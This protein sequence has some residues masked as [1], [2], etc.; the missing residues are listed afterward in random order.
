[1]DEGYIKFNCHWIE[2]PPTSAIQL[3]ELNKWRDILYQR[4]LIGAYPNGI[5][6]GNISIRVSG[7]TFIITGSATGGLS[8]LNESHF[9]LVKDYS[10]VQNSVT[11]TGPIK[12]SSESLSHAVIYE[13]SPATHAVLHIHNLNMWKKLID[14]VPTTKQDITYG[15]PEMANEIKRLFQQT[16]VSREKII[17]MAGH[18]EGIIA[19]G[20]TLDEAGDIL[21][22]KWQ[23]LTN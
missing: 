23:Q 18:T 9:V 22:A 5:G 19:F 11:C 13:C 3:I 2:A 8:T 14:V 21:L 16:D 4:G 10:F 15:T 6:F 17:A 12:A 20:N 7:N 1:M